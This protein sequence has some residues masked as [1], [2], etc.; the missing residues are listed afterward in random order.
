MF[1]VNSHGAETRGEAPTA[2]AAQ[3]MGTIQGR[4]SPHWRDED[5][6]DLLEQLN[7][8]KRKVDFDSYDITVKELISMSDELI[9]VAPEYQRQFRWDQ[10]RQSTFIES[11]F[12]GIPVPSLFTAANADGTWELIDG[13]QRLNTLIHFAAGEKARTR[14]NLGHP[15][16][17]VGLR[18]LS[19]YNGQTFEKL[20]QP[21]QIQFLLKPLKVTTISDK[22]DLTVRFD[23]FERLN[24]GGVLLTPQEIRACIFRGAFND[25]LREMAQLQDF[26]RLVRLPRNKEN[27]GTRE[28]FVLRFFAYRDGY[29]NFEHLVVE[30][31]NRYM[32]KASKGFEYE[33]NREE[34]AEV[35][36]ALA[37]ALPN[38]LVRGK[39]ET[40]ANLFEGVSV[41]AAIALRAKGAI[42]TKGIR[43]WL[44]SNDLK[45]FTSGGTNTREMVRKRIEY[46]RD[47]FLGV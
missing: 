43:S 31:L 22:S 42:V 24:T 27:D 36:G 8:Q 37:H 29:K 7:E 10:E 11:V 16:V 32:E 12:L 40:P 6:S 18:K 15:L 45:S 19:D 34:F 4:R 25:F 33:K 9:N 46:C 26:R 38:G 41:G 30:F 14:F 3:H 20:P 21:A 47:K 2:R 17:L 23:L 44:N 5:M 39:R 28:E 13:V 1:P 35:F